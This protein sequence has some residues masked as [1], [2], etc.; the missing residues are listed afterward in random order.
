MNATSRESRSSLATITGPPALRAALSAAA[1]FGLQSSASAPLPV[2]TST[3]R[4]LMVNPFLVAKASMAATWVSR[5][6]A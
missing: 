2:S 3:K 4:S 5:P 1:S 6:A